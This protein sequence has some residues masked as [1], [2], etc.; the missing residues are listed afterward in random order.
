[1]LAAGEPAKVDAERLGH[2][3]VIITL[4]TYA[5]V[6]PGM[7]QAAATRHSTLLHG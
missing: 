7:Q 1:M 2:S 6:L 4:N 5:H 3:N